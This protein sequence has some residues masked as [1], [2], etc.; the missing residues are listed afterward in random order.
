MDSLVAQYSRPAD[1]DEGPSEQEQLEL[2]SGTPELSLK[3]ALPPVAQ[4][5]RE[6]SQRFM[7][8]C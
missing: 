6:L 2:Y 4:V 5:Q 7:Y 8:L 3:F 1:A